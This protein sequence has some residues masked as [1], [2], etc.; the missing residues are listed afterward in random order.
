MCK[1]TSQQE[2]K[3]LSRGPTFAELKPIRHWSSF[4]SLKAT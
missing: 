3:R 1:R 4:C 2:L